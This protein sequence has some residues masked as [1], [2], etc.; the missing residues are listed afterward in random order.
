MVL[1]D[2]GLDAASAR[3]RELDGD[4]AL[5]LT[6]DVTDTAALADAVDRTVDRFGSLDVVFANASIAAD[7][8]ATMATIDRLGFSV[9]LVTVR[10]VGKFLADPL[11][12]VPAEVIA[13]LR[14][15]AEGR[16]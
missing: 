16:S 5:A 2:L 7:P 15:V 11:G 14:T 1:A 12:G 9:Q 6:V 3:A 10:Y 4:R 13:T 8:P